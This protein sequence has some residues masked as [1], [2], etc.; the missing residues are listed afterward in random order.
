MNGAVMQGAATL[1]WSKN[2]SRWKKIASES[3]MSRVWPSDPECFG[4]R[5]EG[6]ET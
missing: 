6:E 2:P 1:P 5:R 4:P 3:G